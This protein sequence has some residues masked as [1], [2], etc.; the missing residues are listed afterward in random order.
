MDINKVILTGIADSHPIL[1]TLPLSHTQMCQFTLRVDEQFVNEKSGHCSRPNFFLIEGL[2]KQ[3]NI[4]Y[5]RV[6]QGGRYL[7]D[8]Y[9]RQE[10]KQNQKKDIVKVRCYGVVEDFTNDSHCYKKGL[11]K[12]LAILATCTDVKTAT[13]LVEELLDRE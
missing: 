10:Y 3:A 12:A 11:E 2:G 6:K 1:T 9:L 7:V 13:R 5:S 8:G 4:V